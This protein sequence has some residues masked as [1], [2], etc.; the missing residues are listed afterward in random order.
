M[1]DTTQD[2]QDL[3]DGL[4]DRS[5]TGGDWPPTDPDG[6]AGE[7]AAD[8]AGDAAMPGD[9]PAGWNAGLER[10]YRRE[11]RAL[12]R[13]LADTAN[14]TADQQERSER[15]Y[16][17]LD[18]LVNR[19]YHD[20]T[21]EDLPKAMAR[22]LDQL[23]TLITQAPFH[24]P[25]RGPGLWAKMPQ[26]TIQEM[27]EARPVDLT[28]DPSRTEIDLMMLHTIRM[29]RFL[30][31]HYPAWA[32]ALPAC[33]IRHD[34]VVQEVYAL[35]CYM[36]MV[37]ASPNGG[38]YAPS[39]QAA[40]AGALERVKADLTAGDANAQGHAHHLS[41][42]E[43]VQRED[44]RLAE[45]RSW[46]ERS[47]G[48]QAEPPFEAG[49]RYSSAEQAVA[50]ATDLATPT[51]PDAGQDDDGQDDGLRE[52]IDGW[53]AQARNLRA[54]YEQADN[55]AEREQAAAGAQR[56]EE[57]VRRAWLEYTARE[58]LSRDRLDRQSTA[59]VRMLHDGA[60][61]RMD[62]ATRATLENLVEQ[63]RRIIREHGHSTQDEHYEP[64]SASMQD[65]LSERIGR[66]IDGDPSLVF[67]RIDT[68]LDR[69]A[70]TIGGDA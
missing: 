26:D 4:V 21:G 19:K 30:T 35:K 8:T 24:E 32:H 55:E 44:A 65:D 18:E 22:N 23:L 47:G 67:D 27:V 57:N 29:G 42:T 62:A 15:A 43:D 64:V 25:E 48:W 54:R 14:G 7:Q 11:A 6:M 61:A 49:W 38:M 66:L 17:E 28:G 39:L 3:F 1:S 31:T 60:A 40:I 70:S 2:A 46:H 9:R 63:A 56:V 5:G 59:A 13:R 16:R 33:W 69:F 12:R 37:V 58:A 41:T 45:Y 68:R 10:A 50:E 53:R 36:D 34:D 20:L 51:R 52:R